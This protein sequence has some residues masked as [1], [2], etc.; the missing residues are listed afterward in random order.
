MDELKPN[1]RALLERAR[2]AVTPSGDDVDAL[3]TRL[4]LPPPP[5]GPSGG[6]PGPAPTGAGRLVLVATVAAALV[7]GVAAWASAPSPT[8]LAPALSSVPSPPPP[9]PAPTPPPPPV[10]E[11]TPQPEPEAAAPP[12]PR[13]S[14][15]RPAPEPATV[16]DDLGA[17]LALILRARRALK[18]DEN[19]AAR[20]AAASYLRR[21]P[22]GAFE[23]E[24]RA[25]E[26]IA[27]C[28]LEPTASL[29]DAARKAVDD[30]SAFA[31][32]IRR[33]CLEPR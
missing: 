9:T 27:K 18:A 32:R 33:A 12:R 16:E 25:L 2:A 15:R 7:A 4:G 21:F 23:R 29:R 28:N 14:K 19:A 11:E 31:P 20:D 8:R 10:A 24:A 17:E 22:S 30:G 1:A 3:A 6:E 13:T 5:G 26:L